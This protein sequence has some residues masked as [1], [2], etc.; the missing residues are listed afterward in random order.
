MCAGNS[1][2]FS[3]YTLELLNNG[4][5]TYKENTTVAIYLKMML[6]DNQNCFHVLN[7]R[8]LSCNQS[9]RIA[10]CDVIQQLIE[11]AYMSLFT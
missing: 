6:F 2:K 9:K 1:T 10:N 7:S 8:F 5:N 11:A 3:Y 4:I